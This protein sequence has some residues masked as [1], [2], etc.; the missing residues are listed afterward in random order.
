MTLA[1]LLTRV[2][3][4]ILPTCEVCG[5]EF[6]PDPFDLAEGIYTT[7]RLCPDHYETHCFCVRCGEPYAVDGGG[8]GGLC[9]A[10]FGHLNG[11]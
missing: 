3:G 11:G 2:D 4:I 7:L 1:D 10:C 8:D 9:N 6:E 5:A